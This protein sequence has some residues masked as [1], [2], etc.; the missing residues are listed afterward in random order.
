[1]DHD[2]PIDNLLGD[3]S[4]VADVR[5]VTQ[6]DRGG[7][8]ATP[9]LSHRYCILPAEQAVAVTWQDRPRIPTKHT[10]WETMKPVI[11]D[12]YISKNVRLKGVIEIMQTAYQFRATARMYKAQFARWNWH[13]YRTGSQDDTW[14]GFASS[15]SSVDTNHA[16]QLPSPRVSGGRKKGTA[17]VFGLLD[18]RRGDAG[19]GGGRGGGRGGGGPV[20]AHL[21]EADESRHLTT[22]MSAYRSFIL[23]WSEQDPRRRAATSF[24]KMGQYNPTFISHFI[25]ALNHFRNK[26]VEPGGRMLRCAFLELEELI[27][28]GHVAAI[29]DCCISV[30]QLT[31]NYG[32]KDILLTFLRYLSRLSTAK[33]PGHPLA[34]IARST[35]AFVEQNFDQ[36][37]QYTTVAWRLWADTIIQ[38]LGYD[39][40]STLH[41]NRA[42]LLLQPRTD[43]V[44]ARRLILDYDRL[45][46]KAIAS[47]GEDNTATLALEFDAL[48]MQMRFGMPDTDFERRLEKVI[49]KLTH[50]PG[51]AGFPPAIWPAEDRQIYRGCWYLSEVYADATGNREKAKECRRAFL[52]APADADWVQ[53]AVR[54]EERLRG[55]GRAAEA[56]EVKRHRLKLQLPRNIVE[57]LDAE[58]REL[59]E[60]G[61]SSASKRGSL[62]E[63][64]QS[65][66]AGA[67]G[68]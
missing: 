14:G 13:K 59:S 42:Y 57:I 49:C 20:P 5:G 43:P 61:A 19:G 22:A 4:G 67:D 54:I 8:L 21:L 44:L 39:N 23:G 68:K 12:L 66:G 60:N 10:D 11:E 50:K 63:H 65:T 16:R 1:M 55:Q 28:D 24:T 15:G 3:G 51:N 45:V 52:A 35:L 37:S 25:V 17:R 38:L 9:V 27:S 32:R 41:T 48:L 36:V 40:I 46:L 34:H 7:L 56:D 47:L 29:W 2:E 62:S 18:Q 31:L 58:E 53:F 64:E 30:P 26:E 33:A 6:H